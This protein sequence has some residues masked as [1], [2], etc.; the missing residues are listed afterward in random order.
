MRK[1][2]V[3]KVVLGL[4]LGGLCGLPLAKESWAKAPEELASAYGKFGFKLFGNLVGRRQDQNVFVSPASVAFALAMTYNGAAGA[5]E[6]AMARTLEIQGLKLDELNRANAR[7]RQALSQPDPQIKLNIAN[8]LWLRQG[9]SFKPDFLKRNEEF[10]LAAVKVLSFADPQAPANINDWVKKETEGKI[11]RIVGQLQP[12]TILFL[13]NATYFKGKWAQ[14]FDPARTKERPFT[15][16]GGQVRQLPMM[17]QSGFYK[18]YRGKNFQAVSLPYGKN[19]RWSMKIFLP[20]QNSSLKEFLSQLNAANWQQWLAGFKG[21]PGSIVLPR[22]KLEYEASLK[23]PLTALGMGAPFDKAKADFSGL[24]PSPP[25]VYI[26]DVMHKT[27]LEVNEEGTEAAAATAV[28]VAATGRPA[29]RPVFTMVVDR[30]FFLA[31][32]DSETGVQLF[33]G[34]VAEPK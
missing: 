29:P 11:T 3:V 16:L 2:T 28:K 22:F 34:A 24:S 4:V 17:S 21:T 12:S 19:Q 7:L 1:L 30:P 18:Y 14:P 10:Y 26:D 32:D 23:V 33:L 25:T 27:F 8:S 5:T 20:D 13:I 9:L 6:Q 15:L 31:I